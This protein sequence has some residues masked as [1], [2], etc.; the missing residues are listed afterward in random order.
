MEITKK[1][2][3]E[4]LAAIKASDIAAFSTLWPAPGEA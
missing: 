2:V 4:D 1:Q 3:V